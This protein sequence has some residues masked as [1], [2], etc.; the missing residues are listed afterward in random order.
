VNRKDPAPADGSRS[1]NTDQRIRMV[2]GFGEKT[3]TGSIRR[4]PVLTPVSAQIVYGGDRY[5]SEY[6]QEEN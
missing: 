2:R 1:K 3:G 4:L 6:Q 5:W